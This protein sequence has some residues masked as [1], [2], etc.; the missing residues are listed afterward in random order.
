MT[1]KHVCAYL[2]YRFSWLELA[3]PGTEHQRWVLMVDPNKPRCELQVVMFCPYCGKDLRAD[4]HW[5]IPGRPQENEIFRNARFAG[6][7]H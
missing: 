7:A 4:L 5:Q 3:Y 1:T 2:E 6:E